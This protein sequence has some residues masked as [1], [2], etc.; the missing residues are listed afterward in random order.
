MGTNRDELAVWEAVRRDAPTD[1]AA[2]SGTG[3]T[4]EVPN[5]RSNLQ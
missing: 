4:S 2:N 3:N 5:K 1:Q